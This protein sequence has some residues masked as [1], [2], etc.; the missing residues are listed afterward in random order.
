[1]SSLSTLLNLTFFLFKYIGEMRS[2]RAAE[3]QPNSRP[4]YTKTGFSENA[5]TFCRIGRA[6]TQSWSFYSNPTFL[7]ALSGVDEFENWKR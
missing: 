5:K 2:E 4:V 1:M 3:V 7:E 6:F